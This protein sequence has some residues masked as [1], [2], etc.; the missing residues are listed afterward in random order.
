MAT[1]SAQFS[2]DNEQIIGGHCVDAA[3]LH[4]GIRRKCIKVLQIT[5]AGLRIPSSQ[6]LIKIRIT[7]GTEVTA[8]FKRAVTREYAIDLQSR[9]DESNHVLNGRETHDVRG[10]ARE[11]GIVCCARQ[12][13]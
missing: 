1:V 2:P 3:S 12:I 7:F 8:L 5:N 11:N 10:V 9:P 4:A 6:P 13:R